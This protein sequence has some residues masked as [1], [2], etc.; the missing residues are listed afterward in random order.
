LILRGT[1]QLSPDH[2]FPVEQFRLGGAYSV[3]GYQDTEFA[4]DYGADGSIEAHYKLNFMPSS[5]KMPFTGEPVNKVAEV[6]VFFDAGWAENVDPLAGQKVSRKLGGVGGGLR[7][8]LAEQWYA[9]MEWARPVGRDRDQI[10]EI[11][12]TI[13]YFGISAE[14]F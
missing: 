4:G 14:L 3:R 1:T 12:N 6:L 2:L 7:L 13:F 5:W 8:H 10:D 9:R 11:Q